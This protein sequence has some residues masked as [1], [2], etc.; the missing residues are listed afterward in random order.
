MSE[1]DPRERS[2]RISEDPQEGLVSSDAEKLNTNRVRLRLTDEPGKIE[3]LGLK[4]KVRRVV[5]SPNGDQKLVDEP[6]D[7]SR[8]RVFV[9]LR[10]HV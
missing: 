6:Q 2:S 3:V 4:V 7:G 1:G 9:C 8:V 5:Q 10:R